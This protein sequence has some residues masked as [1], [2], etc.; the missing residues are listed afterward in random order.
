[1]TVAAVAF[2]LALAGLLFWLRLRRRRCAR[3][4]PHER[5][6]ADFLQPKGPRAPGT[7]PYDS[8]YQMYAPASPTGSSVSLASFISSTVAAGASIA[9]ASRSTPSGKWRRWQLEWRSE[10]Q[11][12]TTTANGAVSPSSPG[13]DY[14][15][16]PETRYRHAHNRNP[17]NSTGIGA[18]SSIAPLSC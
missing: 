8:P 3:V 4:S 15:L 12:T 2:I 1:V 16:N 17:S 6:Q 14:S 7:S 9:S 11:S 5:G 18:Q 13:T 10:A